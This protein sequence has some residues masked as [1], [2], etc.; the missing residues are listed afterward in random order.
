MNKISTLVIPA[1]GLGTRLRPITHITPKE[2]IRIVDKP[3]FYYLLKE[4]YEASINKVVFIIHKDNRKLESFFKTN[5]AKEILKEFGDMKIIFVK[6]DKRNGDGQAILQTK[7]LFKKD[8]FFA[9]SMGDFLSLPNKSVINELVNEYNKNYSSI[10]S[11]A[12]VPKNQ[13]Y[14]YGVISGKKTKKNIYKVNSIVEKPK[15]EESPSNFAMTAKYIISSNIFPILEKISYEVKTGEEIKLANALNIFA[16]DNT[17][18][19]C[20]TMNTSYDMGTKHMLAQTELI[21]SMNNLDIKKH[22]MSII[23]KYAR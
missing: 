13:V 3:V 4:A 21:F 15:P 10:I 17:L 7:K 6:T 23:K 19:A 8:E 11:I 16:K 12:K 14:L 9:V 5:E 2:M 18:C 1:A 20:E 22:L